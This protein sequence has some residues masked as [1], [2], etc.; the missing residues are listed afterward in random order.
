MNNETDATI[1][2]RLER[3]RQAH[4]TRP[5]PAPKPPPKPEVDVRPEMHALAGRLEFLANQ[6]EG[7][8]TTASCPRAQSR[9]IQQALWPI[10]KA[11]EELR[12]A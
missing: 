10:R 1:Q 12:K 8:A 6:L 4:Q 2:E 5:I 7:I 3:L 9:A 11:A